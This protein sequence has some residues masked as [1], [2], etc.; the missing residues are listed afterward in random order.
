MPSNIVGY[1]WPVDGTKHVVFVT[2][3]DHIHALVEQGKRW[4]DTDVT[5]SASA[6]TIPLDVATMTAYSWP[7]GRTQQIDYVS[8]ADSAGHI[9]EL[10]QREGNAW[11]YEDLMAQPTGA[12]AA[13]GTAL[14]GY[15]WRSNGT[16][17]IVY[18]SGDGHIHELSAGTVGE[19]QYTNITQQANAPRAEGAALTSFAWEVQETR[20][21]AYMSGDGHIHEL[22]VGKDNVW[23]HTDVTEKTGTPDASEDSSLVGYIWESQS[24]E[25]LIYTTNGGSI[26]ALTAAK[27]GTWKSTDLLEKTQAPKAFGSALAGYVWTTGNTQQVVYMSEDRHI[28]ELST[29]T[30]GTWSHT[31]V[32]RTTNA[33]I[34][35]NDILVGF[36]WSSAF[37]KQIVYLDTAENPHL[38][39]L[40]L[41]HGSA[42]KHTDITT[43]TGASD[44]V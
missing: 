1:E 16:K 29:G 9:R 13:D 34:A 27:D 4:I 20:H 17:H 8:P 11:S 31:D 12:P 2:G 33:P 24:T 43:L 5:Q 37:A 42:W 14:I 15:S 39:E 7:T 40:M 3:D 18:T 28:Q 25:N 32:T 36:E 30:D 6:P 26:F 22:T 10:V 44:L 41:A 19:W 38:H 21:V 23:Q 35:A